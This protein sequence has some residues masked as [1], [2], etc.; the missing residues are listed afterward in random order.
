M[1]TKDEI[2]ADECTVNFKILKERVQ[3]DFIKDFFLTPIVSLRTGANH[4][5]CVELHVSQKYDISEDT[6]KSFKDLLNADRWTF[7]MSN[8]Q[9]F[10]RFFVHF[11][12]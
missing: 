2:L 8:R 9:L 4:G 7:H 12:Q 3:K 10:L 5:Y 1:K 6:M 11:K